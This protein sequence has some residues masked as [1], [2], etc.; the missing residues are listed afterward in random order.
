[1]N[2]RGISLL[3]AVSFSVFVLV[4]CAPAQRSQGNQS[5]SSASLIQTGTRDSRTSVGAVIP[6]SRQYLDAV[7]QATAGKTV[8]SHLQFRYI[9]QLTPTLSV[10]L[11]T[12]NQNGKMLFNETLV[13]REKGK[14]LVPGAATASPVLNSSSLTLMDMNGSYGGNVIGNTTG[15]STPY[16]I[17]GGLIHDP[18]I[19]EVELTDVLGRKIRPLQ[20][21]DIGKLKMYAYAQVMPSQHIQEWQI[22]TYDKFGSLI[23]P[24]SAQLKG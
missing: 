16:Q 21:V 11:Y 10:C 17:I 18:A 13:S 7:L 14:W 5:T 8:V 23:S 2:R 12:F 4:G 22:R 20:I 1:M 3:I 19:A 6:P 9:K 24:S 15:G